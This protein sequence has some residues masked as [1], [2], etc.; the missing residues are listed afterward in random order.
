MKEAVKILFIIFLLINIPFKV[1]AQRV[2]VTDNKGTLI[3]TGN[4]VTTDPTAPV[5]PTPIEGD[6]WRD[7]TNTGNII[8]YVYDGTNWVRIT[9]L[10]N[11]VY[12]AATGKIFGNGTAA[13]TPF[14]ST[15]T[16]LSRGRYRVDFTTAMPDANYIIQLTIRDSNGAGND[17]YDISYNTQT[18]TSFIVEIGDNDNGGNNRANRDNEFTYVVIDYN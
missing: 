16:R 7:N 13:K 17:D 15:V 10:A 4:I 11:S 6:I 12:I 8:S 18:T 9:P 5:S 14:N 3:N 1:F 2:N